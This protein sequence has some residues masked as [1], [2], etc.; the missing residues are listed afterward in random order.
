MGAL[1]PIHVLALL[2]CLLSL[3]VLIG[4]GLWAAR[5]RSTGSDS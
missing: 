3:A 4:G 2:F 5:R 1:K